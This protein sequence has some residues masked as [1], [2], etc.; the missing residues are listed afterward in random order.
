MGAGGEQV[1]RQW[2]ECIKDAFDKC[3]PAG[4]VLGGRTVYAVQEFGCGDGGYAGLFG[5]AELLGQPGGDL[6]H[7]AVM[8][9]TADGALQLD[10]DGG[11]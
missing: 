6:G 1:E 3:F 11:V 7:R 9:E 5:R 8:G 2:W 10:E 4:S